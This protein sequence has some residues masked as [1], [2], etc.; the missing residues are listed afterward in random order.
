MNSAQAPLPLGFIQSIAHLLPTELGDFL[1]A[2]GGAPHR[3]LRFSAR[4]EQPDIDGLEGPVPWAHN[5]YYIKPGAQLGAHPLHWAGAYYI[6][7]P[8]A[9]AAAAALGAQPGERV[10]DVCAAPGGKATQ[11]ADMMRGQGVLIANDPVLPRARELSRNIERMGIQ[12]A[13]VLS[14]TAQ[15]L[16]AAFPE[17]FDRVL[18]DAPCSGEGMFRKEPQSM[19]HWTSE[20]PAACAARQTDIVSQAAQ[21][22]KPGGSLVYSTCTFNDVENEG[23]IRAFLQSHPNFA[24]QPFT[25]PG[26]GEAGDGMLRMWPH[27]VRGEGH[28][29]ALMTKR[30]ETQRRQYPAPQATRDML[31]VQ[32]IIQDWVLD[33]LHINDQLGD[34]FTQLPAGTPP[35]HGLRVLRAGLHIAQRVGKTIRPDHALALACAPRKTTNLTLAQADAYRRGEVLTIAN[36]ALN[37]FVAPTL[38]GWPLGWAKAGEGQLK[39]R[40]PK[41]LRKYSFSDH[42]YN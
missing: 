39:N 6:Q 2:F 14:N 18:V 36:H 33:D 4:R 3:A 34:V 10:L 21:T 15:Q 38:A 40:Y 29:V 9:M 24:L 8:S 11:L 25:L 17:T 37:G 1:D 30:G 16:A 35:L 31:E 22:L 13:V 7:E 42:D 28:F 32:K 5:A 41:G 20:A 27:R 12:N 23:V 19:Q 26:L